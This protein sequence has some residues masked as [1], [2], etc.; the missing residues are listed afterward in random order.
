MNIFGRWIQRNVSFVTI[1]LN[2]VFMWNH[3]FEKSA[4]V[5]I[6]TIVDY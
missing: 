5:W 4:V 2:T 1:W 3:H 6:K